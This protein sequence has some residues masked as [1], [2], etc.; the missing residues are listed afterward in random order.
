MKKIF[1]P[2]GLLTVLLSGCSAGVSSSEKFVC[3]AL[4]E[5][6]PKID[7]EEANNFLYLYQASGVSRLGDN[8]ESSINLSQNS[9]MALEL[10]ESLSA[11]DDENL[12]DLVRLHQLKWTK[13]SNDG[14][15]LMR[16]VVGSAKDGRNSLNNVQ[17]NLMLQSSK[18]IIEAGN[19]AIRIRSQCIE[20]G[21]EKS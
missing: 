17:T 9:R 21:F 6:W 19:L 10:R 14:V 3:D 7:F 4:F 2:I 18:A 1:L 20:I 8:S 11:N 16:S 5:S 12:S 13:A 15:L